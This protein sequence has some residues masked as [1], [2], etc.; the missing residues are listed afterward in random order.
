MKRNTLN[1]KL[2]NHFI[3]KILMI[4]IATLLLT[5]YFNKVLAESEETNQDFCYLSDI[6]YVTSQ[7]ST[8]WGQIHM[9][10]AANGSKISVKVQDYWYEFDKGIWAHANS[11][12]VYDLRNY[13][14]Y[15]YFTAYIGLNKTAASSSDGVKFFIYTSVDGTK[16]DLKTEANTQVTKPGTNATFVKIDIK[17][18]N[19]LKLSADKNGNNGND[20]SVYADPKLIKEGYNDSYTATKTVE[21]YDELIKSKYNGGEIDN[22][23]ELLLLQREVVKNAGQYQLTRFV[24]ESKKNGNYEECQETFN[25]LFNNL[26]MLR[27]YVA[28]GKPDGTYMKSLQVLTELRKAYKDDLEISGTTESGVQLK[29]IYTKMII[30]L[31]LSHSQTVS[32][33]IHSAPKEAQNAPDPNPNVSDAKNRY[34]IYKK[35]LAN[36]KINVAIFEQLEVEEMRY[37]MASFIN[38]DEIEWACDFANSKSNKYSGY[39]YM[40]YKNVN[41]ALYRSPEFYA[42]GRK[43]Y[44]EKY[45]LAGYDVKNIEYYPRLWMIM[46]IGGVCWQISNVGQNMVASMGIPTTIVGQPGHTAYLV[47]GRNANGRGTW[48]LWND[49][50]GWETT[51]AVGYTG[52]KTYYPIR[53]MCNWG[54]GSYASSNK[55]SYILL[56]QAAIDDYDNYVKARENVMLAQIY[57]NDNPKAEAAYRKALS[58]QPIH[59]DAWA[60]VVNIYIN[61]TTKTE[62]DLYNLAVELTNNLKYY[63]LPMT[64][65]LKLIN[66]KITSNAYKVKFNLLE[67]K[68]LKEAAAATDAQAV[69]SRVVKRM[70]NYLL[71]KVD[72]KV[73]DFSFDGENAGVLSLSERYE[74]ST[75][76]WDYSLDGGTTWTEVDAQ[77]KKLSEEEINSI[78]LENDMKIHIIGVNYDP[79]N[80]Y[81]ID[82][83]KA[84]NPT[85]L[86][87]NDLENKVIGVTD[88]EE[89]RLSDSDKWTSYKEGEPDLAGNKQVQIRASANGVYLPSDETTYAFTQN[90]EEETR[91]YIP[92]SHLSIEKVSSEESGKGNMARYAIDGNINNIWHTLWNGS[93]SERYIV[94][95]LD[96][97]LY[98]S[99]LEYIPRQD[100][101]NGRLKNGKLSLSIDGENWTEVETITNWTNDK[102]TKVIN[103][104]EPVKAKYVKLQATES[105]GGSYLSAAMIN[106]FQDAT[107]QTAPTASVEYSTIEPTNQNVIATINFSEDVTILN[108]EREFTKQNDGSYTYTF[109]NNDEFTLEFQG[110][111]EQKGT[112][113][114]KVNW[115]DKVKP[116]AQVTYDIQTPTNQDVIATIKFSEEVT[117]TS[118]TLQYDEETGLYKYEFI[119]NG[120]FCLKFVDAVGNEGQTE[121]S[122]NWINKE[123]P[124]ADIIY[125]KT[126]ETEESV[127]ATL[128]CSEEITIT[129]NDGKNTHTFERNGE[130]TFT[131]VD[132][133]GNEGS[134][135]AKVTWIKQKEEIKFTSEKYKIEEG[136]V[137]KIRTNTTVR[138]I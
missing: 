103:L 97:P 29:D 109:E 60:G 18:A 14:Q 96:E 118:G 19:Y 43:N 130:F 69:Q 54:D 138:R 16:W 86:Y 8:S 17:E 102:N 10:Q 104:Q 107:K 58:I 22:E 36:K 47:Y 100:A 133:L 9:D 99:A 115:I 126:E 4:G 87:N 41:T 33:W 114:L 84:S 71:G 121:V 72:T 26:D 1:Y 64:D 98:I 74:A 7:S 6:Q 132:K 15:D 59:L 23:L 101:S 131:Y 90:N 45:K 124:E 46:E 61:D 34:A 50:G 38:D 91:K 85:K 52:T 51:N 137:S 25:W 49:V 62:E 30:S 75:A 24:E 35:L 113:D 78:T 12:L 116:T 2:K 63:P 81:T 119:E 110:Q 127:T 5:T 111:D 66:G 11:N 53:M 32:F 42:K 129:N 136:Y 135:T 21:E 94:I 134:A 48:D 108:K 83:L 128:T 88:K 112:L 93:D 92:I 56:S 67:T 40:D 89:W 44:E 82:I 122:V 76:H 28:G 39:S 77:S 73:A 80:I 27:M 68:T 117:I 55:G 105:H 20:H 120:G 123:D 65:L 13:K 3:F 70:A 106:L 57:A 31:S 125:D 37:I 95:K 79:E